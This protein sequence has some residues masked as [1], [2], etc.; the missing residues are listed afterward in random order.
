MPSHVL[1]ISFWKSPWFQ[2]KP[3][4]P[5]RVMHGEP[6]AQVFGLVENKK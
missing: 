6:D 2:A 5:S 1:V 3:F 4:G